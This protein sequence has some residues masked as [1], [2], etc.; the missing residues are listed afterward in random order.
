MPDLDAQSLI[1]W[2]HFI[3]LVLV[4]GSIPVCLI[5]S[6]FEDTHE[7][8]RGLSAVIWKKLTRWGMRLAILCG[9]AL[10]VVEMAKGEKPFAQ[11]HLMFKLG[12][13][14]VMVFLSESTPKALGIGKRGSATLALMIFIF[15]SFIAS[16]HEAFSK[17]E[18]PA[19]SVVAP[20]IPTPEPPSVGP[21]TP[22]QNSQG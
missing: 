19:P 7:D 12:I 18:A 6:G 15:T 14:A 10:F 5:L 22:Q 13:G 20:E 3:F 1:G 16:N 8:I 21:E 17:T 4:G 2:L 11:P 9:L